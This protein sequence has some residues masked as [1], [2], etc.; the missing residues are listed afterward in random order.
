MSPFNPLQSPL[1]QG[2]RVPLYA[3]VN[4]MGKENGIMVKEVGRILIKDKENVKLE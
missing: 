2:S 4:I 3:N 1:M